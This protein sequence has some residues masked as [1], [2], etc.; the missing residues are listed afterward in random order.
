V[1]YNERE[2]QL[3]EYGAR[4]G[5]WRKP[6]KFAYRCGRQLYAGVE[7]A[8]KR[9]LDVGCGNGR[10]ALWAAAAGAARVLGLEPA[11]AGSG[12]N[13]TA[14]NFRKAIA[15]LG[16]NNA[17]V[18]DV[19]FQQF[20]SSAGAWDVVLSYASVNHLDEPAC[21]ALGRDPAAREEYMKIFGKLRKIVSPGGR[22]ILT[23]SS[24]R[25]FFA[26]V[27]PLR[28]F[29]PRIDWH[30][31]QPPE[32]WAGLLVEAGFTKPEISWPSSKA[33]PISTALFSNRLA[34]YFSRSAFRMVVTAPA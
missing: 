21:E 25:N 1:H 11:M 2:K 34:A 9:V 33:D 20:E 23:D 14:D 27:R 10:F 29:G 31:H 26:D 30:K 16:F 22:V 12:V 6:E 7:L 8:G 5:W 4:T 17:E 32:V 28:R 19:T 24:S 3:L 13:N 15:T 18:Q